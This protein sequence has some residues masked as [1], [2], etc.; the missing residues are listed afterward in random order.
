MFAIK[1]SEVRPDRAAPGPSFGLEILS[2]GGSFRGGEKRGDRR[3][4]LTAGG[5]EQTSGKAKRGKEE[6]NVERRHAHGQECAVA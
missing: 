1:C 2:I 3:R 4:G 5:A 6:C